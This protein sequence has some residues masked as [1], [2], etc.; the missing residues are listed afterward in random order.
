MRPFLFL[1]LALTSCTVPD[2]ASLTVMNETRH[3][4]KSPVTLK[5]YKSGKVT[6][7]KLELRENNSFAYESYIVGTQKSVYYAGTFTRNQDTL[8]LNFQNNHKDSLWTGKA[9]I[10]ST[11][12]EITLISNDA[13][14]NKQL[15][16][17]KQK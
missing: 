11:K 17:S 9:V 3:L 2:K 15:T 12:N 4:R 14:N 1:L 6:N 10:D 16:I 13:S 7:D 8:V 5:A